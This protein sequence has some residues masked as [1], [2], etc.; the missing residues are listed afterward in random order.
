MRHLQVNPIAGQHQ[1]RWLFE[2]QL[3]ALQ[4]PISHWWAQDQ[5]DLGLSRTRWFR[6]GW[7]G[8]YNMAQVLRVQR[9]VR[10]QWDDNG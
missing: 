3:L 7:E 8:A 10:L 1:R 6:S 4:S 2:A 5:L 9:L